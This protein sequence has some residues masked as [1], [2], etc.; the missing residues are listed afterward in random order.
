[1][2]SALLLESLVRL[3]SAFAQQALEALLQL[4]KFCARSPVQG[5]HDCTDGNYGGTGKVI[6]AS[7]AWSIKVGDQQVV[8]RSVPV[9]Q[10]FLAR[11]S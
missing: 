8:M 1:M 9:P 3:R 10:W 4:S 2:A 7:I 11:R 6:L 5:R